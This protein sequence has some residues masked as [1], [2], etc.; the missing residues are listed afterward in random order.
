MPMGY[1]LIVKSGR[2][3]GCGDPRPQGSR[4]CPQEFGASL[5]VLALPALFCIDSAHYC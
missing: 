1:E 5:R 3:A 4:L 2:K